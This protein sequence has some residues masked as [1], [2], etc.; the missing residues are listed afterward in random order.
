MFDATPRAPLRDESLLQLVPAPTRGRNLVAMAAG[1]VAL[2]AAFMSPLILRP[3][4]DPDDQFAGGSWQLLDA[5]Q[6]VVAT[7]TVRGNT[8]PRV[9]ISSVGDVAGAHVVGAW[10]IDESI[11]ETGRDPSDFESGVA[12]VEAALAGL[13]AAS[14]ALPQS[15]DRGES[16]VLLVLW[17][18]DDCDA[19]DVSPPAAARAELRTLVGSSRTENLAEIAAPGFALS[20]IR[21]AGGCP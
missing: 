6:Q 7:T 2:I 12:Y 13:A 1:V 11:F 9:E 20:V 5:H 19:L 21:A 18:I 17:S 16:A 4:L 8:W 3:A 15:L 10:L 14:V